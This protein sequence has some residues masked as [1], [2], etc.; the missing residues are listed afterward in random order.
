MFYSSEHSFSLLAA[1]CPCTSVREGNLLMPRASEALHS[2]GYLHTVPLRLD[3]LGLIQTYSV[4]GTHSKARPW[5]FYHNFAKLS[6]RTIPYHAIN[7]RR[8]VAKCLATNR[9]IGTETGCS[10]WRC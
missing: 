7:M 10:L 8:V 2:T 4:Q 6:T 3:L 1:C 9:G 5:A